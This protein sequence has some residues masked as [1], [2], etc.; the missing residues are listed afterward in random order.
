MNNYFSLINTGLIERK[1]HT[2]QFPFSQYLF[3]DTP[4]EMIDIKQHKKYIIER[5]LVKG[6]LSDFYTLLKLYTQDEIAEAIRK[7]KVLDPKTVN[8]CSYYFNVPK[9]ELHASSYY[10]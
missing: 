4:V 8:F 5:V 2:D 3:W 1:L 7:S 9:N 10:S 6:F